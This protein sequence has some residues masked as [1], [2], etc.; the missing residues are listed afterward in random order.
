MLW[1]KKSSTILPTT[2]ILWKYEQRIKYFPLETE[3]SNTTFMW[4]VNT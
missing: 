3:I 2:M 1:E 4:F